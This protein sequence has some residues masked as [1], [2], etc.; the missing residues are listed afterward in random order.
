MIHPLGHLSGVCII[1]DQPAPT[2]RLTG[3][4]CQRCN[5][6][7]EQ[8]HDAILTQHALRHAGAPHD[9]YTEALERLVDDTELMLSPER[10]IRDTDPVERPDPGDWAE[11]LRLPD[12]GTGMQL[13]VDPT[14][15]PCPSES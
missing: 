14:E 4:L 13:I 11:P 15:E 1:C 12:H 7:R 3:G 8:I 5:T 6:L 2:W 9:A 10:D